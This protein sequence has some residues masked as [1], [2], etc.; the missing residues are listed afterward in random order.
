MKSQKE[1]TAILEKVLLFAVA[2]LSA[3]VL[4]YSVFGDNGFLANHS[5]KARHQLL[6]KEVSETER[7]NE[8]LRKEI[9]GLKDDR[10]YIERI[11]REE[12]GMVRE[13]EI[14]FLEEKERGSP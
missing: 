14:L 8:A 10:K 4:G 5:L 13:G 2:I 6:L 9:G 3:V 11:A 1:R 12:L 7:E